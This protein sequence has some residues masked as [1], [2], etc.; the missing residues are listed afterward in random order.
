MVDASREMVHRARRKSEDKK[1][2]FVVLADV[3]HL[4]IKSGVIDGAMCT[5]SLTTIRHP[6]DAV[7]ELTRTL[8]NEGLLVVLDSEK[9]SNP[10]GRFIY[11]ALVPISRLFCHTQIDRDVR[12]IL[13]CN[14][15]LAESGR[16][17]YMGGMVAIHVCKKT[18]KAV[19][20]TEIMVTDYR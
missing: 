12:G 3:N 9:P 20:N 4:P 11:R 2:N 10:A 1:G 6:E 7:E 15:K 13:S 14:G 8:V 5:F 17:G 16:K 18:C 19:D